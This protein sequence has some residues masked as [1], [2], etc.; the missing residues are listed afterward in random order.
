[1]YTKVM[2]SEVK[3]WVDEHMN[4]EDIAMNFLVASVTRKAPIKVT[5]YNFFFKLSN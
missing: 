4:C 2:P 5:V 3:R 1:M